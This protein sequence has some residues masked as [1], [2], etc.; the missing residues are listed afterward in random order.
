[1]AW[2]LR[3]M[4]YNERMNWDTPNRAGTQNRD[5]LTVALWEGLKLARDGI[6]FDIVI[7]S[8]EAWNAGYEELLVVGLD[9][10][11]ARIHNISGEEE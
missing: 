4:W 3:G 1:M 9:A 6:E 11:I 2:N 5:V 7:D 10:R 8:S